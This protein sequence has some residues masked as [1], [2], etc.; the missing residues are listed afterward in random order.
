MGSQ[1]VSPGDPFTSLHAFLLSA[2]G[3]AGSYA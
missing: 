1:T 3:P 2:D